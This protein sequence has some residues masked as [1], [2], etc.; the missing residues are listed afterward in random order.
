M[1]LLKLDCATAVYI[2][3]AFATAVYTRLDCATTVNIR[4]DCATADYTRLDCATTVYKRLRQV[5]HDVTG[6]KIQD[7]NYDLLTGIWTE[8]QPILI[9]KL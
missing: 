9:H 5:S 6:Y 4:L 2:R 8:N 7:K 1:Q 3:L